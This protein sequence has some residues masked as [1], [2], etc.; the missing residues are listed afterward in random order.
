MLGFEMFGF[1]IFGLEM[2]GFEIFGFEMFGFVISTFEMFGFEILGLLR[3]L[4]RVI[5][6]CSPPVIREP[7]GAAISTA[8]TGMVWSGIHDGRG[9]VGSKR[10]DPTGPKPTGV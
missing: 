10:L 9:W 1:E 8:L 4:F 7:L 3:S 2:L 5:E 6:L